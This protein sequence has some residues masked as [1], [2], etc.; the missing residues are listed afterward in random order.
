MLPRGEGAV[1]NETFNNRRAAVDNRMGVER[2][3]TSPWTVWIYGLPA[4][5]LLGGLLHAFGYGPFQ[6][7]AESLNREAE[8]EQS[9]IDLKEE[10]E[11]LTEDVNSLMPGEFG[12]EKRARE[13]LGWSKEGEIIVHIPDKR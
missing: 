1:T 2:Q 5:A 9:I 13:Q 3:R 6:P 8:L 7:V 12:I 11:T 4:V 10:N